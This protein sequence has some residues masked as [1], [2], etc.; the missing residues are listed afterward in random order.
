[1]ADLKNPIVVG[2]IV[3]TIIVICITIFFYQWNRSLQE[4]VTNMENVVSTSIK[5]M[6]GLREIKKSIP[7]FNKTL[8]EHE[9]T[10]S[11]LNESNAA[12]VREVKL[13][14]KNLDITVDALNASGT[15]EV[16]IPKKKKKSPKKKKNNKKSVSFESE[17]DSEESESECSESDSDDDISDVKKALAKMKKKKRRS[18]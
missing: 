7:W 3:L 4:K 2:I 1:M 8:K 15:V 9:E 11:S 5:E 12:L 18:A 14:R 16:K 13:L 17:S 10:I 6:N